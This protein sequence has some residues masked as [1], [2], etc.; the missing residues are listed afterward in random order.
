MNAHVTSTLVTPPVAP[1]VTAEHRRENLGL[2]AGIETRTLI[3]IAERLP[4]WV[5]SDR[6]TALGALSMA[7]VGVAFALAR[8]V[9]WSPAVVPVLLALNWFGDSLDGTVA[10]VRRC[11]RPRYGYYLDHVVDIVCATALFAGLAASTLIHPGL[12]AGL[13]VAYLLLCAESFLATHA[14]GLFRLAISG[15][16][17]TE[18]RI[19]LAVGALMVIE[20]PL[21]H[22]FGLG[23]FRLF[24]VGGSVGLAGML[25]AFL[26][27]VVR[28]T[29]FLYRAEPLP[30]GGR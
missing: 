10:R 6:L 8:Y 26:F 13:L 20:R 28:N 7:G 15:F 25:G 22:P 19:V 4:P 9:P 16:G 30:R 17:P 29:A 18:L 23:T 24:D 11:Q 12:A 3:W 2:L 1:V 5:T 27:T 21:V 14:I